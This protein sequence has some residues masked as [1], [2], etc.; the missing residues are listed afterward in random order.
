[1]RWLTLRRDVPIGV[2]A[3]VLFSLVL[4]AC[5][6]TGIHV[7]SSPQPTAAPGAPT[8]LIRLN[9]GDDRHGGRRQLADYLSDGSVI[10]YANRGLACEPGRPCG[11]LE[12][13][14]LTGAGLA[15]L[16]ANLAEHAGWLGQPRELFNTVAGRADI[17]N[18]FVLQQPDGAR[19]AVRMPSNRSRNDAN[20]DVEL[21]ERLDTLAQAM[22]DPVNLIGPAGLTNP[23]WQTYQPTT[24]AVFIRLSAIPPKPTPIL[25]TDGT[26]I[27]MP[28]DGPSPFKLT[29]TW[30]FD[31]TPGDFGMAFSRPDGT[32]SRCGF[33][34]STNVP[35]LTT[36]VPEGAGG[37]LA[38]GTLA[39]G[40][41]WGSGSLEWDD[42][43]AI[44]LRIV[45]L[46]PEDVSATCADVMAY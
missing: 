36:I 10:R 29:G 13:N 22:V 30:P 20:W 5:G 21:A 11:T 39:M 12:R 7:S 46:L 4:A 42:T 2:A 35:S 16:R 40:R 43:T 9:A 25:G 18:T 37:S 1:M 15:A 3:L 23:V 32:V 28:F 45:A 27:G 33:V 6:R 17:V 38:A 24:M 44:S 14:T 31:A 8:L 34:D 19:Y 26:M 41:T